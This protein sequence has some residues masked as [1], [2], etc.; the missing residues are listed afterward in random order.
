MAEEEKIYD[1]IVT[2]DGLKIIRKR[3]GQF[4]GSPKLLEGEK[5]SGALLQIYQ[6]ILSNAI[7]EAY[8]GYGKQIT[9]IIHKDNSMTVMD[10]GRGMPKGDDFDKVIRSLSVLYSSGKYDAESYAQSIGQNGVGIKATNALSDWIELE[11][12]NQAGDHYRIKMHMEDVIE[13]E[14]LKPVNN[15]FTNITF[16]PD[17]EYF[18]GHIDWEKSNIEDKLEK[19]SYLTPKVKFIFIDERDDTRQEWYSE[20]G[21]ID[22]LKKMTEGEEY[23][24][25]P[26]QFNRKFDDMNVEG[27]IAFL[28]TAGSHIYSFANGVETIDGGPHVNGYYKSIFDTLSE[29]AQAKGFLKRGQRLNAHDVYEG[30]FGTVLVKLPEDKLVFNSQSKTKLQSP[31]ANKIVKDAVHDILIEWLYDHVDEG[32]RLIDNVLAAS[33]ARAELEQNKSRKQEERD[34]IREVKEKSK[35]KMFISRKLVRE[36]DRRSKQKELYI[37][38]GNSALSSLK[39]A[40]MQNQAIFP[41]RG[42]I[43]NT[44]WIPLVDA[45]KNEEVSTIVGILGAGV[46][47]EYK[48]KDLQYDRVVI[49]SDA[50]SDGY[51]IQ[52]LL[53]VLFWKFFPDFVR[54]G[55]LFVAKTP[56]FRMTRYVKGEQLNEYA[57]T[58]EGRDEIT[59]VWDEKK[60]DYR[61]TRFKGL[62]EA[63]AD[64]LRPIAMNPET[65]QL[66]Q[67]VMPEDATP[68][69]EEVNQALEMTM[70]KGDDVRRKW[71]M[72]NLRFDMEAL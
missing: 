72:E 13:K 60:Y 63:D 21:L 4:V 1:T 34:A 11:A 17:E 57:F 51:H 25:E 50:D 41:L 58:V 68:E 42:K 10:E 43:L 49:I 65:R 48:N 36:S 31:E 2:A 27:A 40:R 22:Y 18:D 45:L 69:M 6:E 24:V 54:E 23:L 14:D 26:I 39:G 30:L 16:L 35:D 44:Y 5:N 3:P 52:S 29:F 32:H 47:D 8:A 59:K 61:I 19:S 46:S 67:L 33:E 53:I 37:V 20:N 56:L 70:G 15:T 55:R 71:V 38:E 62:G 12:S 64:D 9:L 7:D 66:V 28:N